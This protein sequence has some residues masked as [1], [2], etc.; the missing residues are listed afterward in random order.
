M[1]SD[2]GCINF[3]HEPLDNYKFWITIDDYR[4][5]SPLIARDYQTG[6]FLLKRF[7]KEA[8]GLFLDHDLGGR[9]RY[10]K[11]G[12]D[13]CQYMCQNELFVKQ[14]MIVSDNPVGIKNIR[15]CLLNNGYESYKGST[16]HFI[17]S[18]LNF[19]K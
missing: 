10:P 7:Y 8:D 5:C 13:V 15:D 3:I 11:T 17:R 4:E 16:I 19:I 6:L 9:G 14:V 1:C 2:C 18:N 12:Y